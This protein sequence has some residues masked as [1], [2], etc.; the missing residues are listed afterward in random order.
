MNALRQ[1][2]PPLLALWLAFALG[3]C[4]EDT[5]GGGGDDPNNDPNNTPNNEPNNQPN[6]TPAGSACD[7]FTPCG[8]DIVGTHSIIDAC[9]DGAANPF[10]EQCPE[11]TFEAD[12]DFSGTLTFN[13]D[14]SWSLSTTT[15]GTATINVPASC[16]GGDCNTLSL[17]LMGAQC[18][19]AGEVC[20]CDLAINDV[21]S[22]SGTFTAEGNNLVMTDSEGDTDTFSICVQGQT[23]FMELQPEAEDDVP[24]TFLIERR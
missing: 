6:N 21:S 19:A 16:V 20:N 9:F 4:G 12:T 22:E 23:A 15:V 13:G 3:A 17:L 18:T 5:G 10:E 8:G 2:S 11:A 14:G 1:V 7:P 24:V